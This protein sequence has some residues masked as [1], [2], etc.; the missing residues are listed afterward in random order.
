M[1]ELAAWFMSDLE[2]NIPIVSVAI[3]LLMGGIWTVLTFFHKV[4]SEREE[5]QFQRYRL[6]VE[7]LNQG[8]KDT[9]NGV[10]EVYID[11]QLNSIYEM[12]FYK[13][14]Y[15]RSER[16]ISELIPRW[17]LSASYN[18]SHIEELKATLKYIKCRKSLFGN[19]VMKFLCVFWPICK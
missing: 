7:E 4:F 16:L 2:K 14:Y 12:R 8:K 6:L 10:R 11:F 19:L 9:E 3:G 18:D 15:A 5:M 1:K 13:K 17:K